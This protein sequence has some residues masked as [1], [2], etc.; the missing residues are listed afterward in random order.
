MSP[1]NW[2][3]SYMSFV[4][5]GQQLVRMMNVVGVDKGENEMKMWVVST[6][7]TKNLTF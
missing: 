5:G 2:L 7:T 3:D 1:S 6:T 4:Y